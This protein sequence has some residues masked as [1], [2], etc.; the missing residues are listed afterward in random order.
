[1]KTL[2]Y[3]FIISVSAAISGQADY[4]QAFPAAEEVID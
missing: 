4:M 3:T 1:M 2:F